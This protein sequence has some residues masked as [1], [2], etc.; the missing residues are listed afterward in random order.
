MSLVNNRTSSPILIDGE[1][2]I[3]PKGLQRKTIMDLHTETH[4]SVKRINETLRKSCSWIR[5]REDIQKIWD[6]CEE[7]KIFQPSLPEG[8]P[9]M[10]KIPL[11]SLQPMQIIH[12]DLFQFGPNHYV[13]TRDQVSS[14]TWF[15]YLGLTNTTK[16]LDELDIIME[17][18][19]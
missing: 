6:E 19:G 7:C 9:R 3:I 17:K 16:V 18:Y 14:Y 10:D 4:S 2:V 1:R 5:M 11:T 12:V 8:R 15:S 13:S